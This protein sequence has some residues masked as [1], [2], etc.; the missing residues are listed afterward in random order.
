MQEAEENAP[1][2][3]NG[4]DLQLFPHPARQKVRNF[5]TLQDQKFLT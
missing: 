1:K 2:R 4:G 5:L 3:R